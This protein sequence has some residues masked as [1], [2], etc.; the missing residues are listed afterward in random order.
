M[1]EH[2]QQRVRVNNIHAQGGVTHN[3]PQVTNSGDERGGWGNHP[4]NQTMTTNTT[5][6]RSQP[7]TQTKQREMTN[8]HD[9]RENIVCLTDCLN[10]CLY[11]S[12]GLP[13]SPL[14]SL[15]LSLSLSLRRSLCVSLSLDLCLSPSFP[16]SLAICLCYSVLERFPPSLPLLVSTFVRP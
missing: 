9:V 16:L 15:C 6:T 14:V 5:E 4:P 11:V 13:L 8:L 3:G 10:G 1:K 7:T 2:N 12:F